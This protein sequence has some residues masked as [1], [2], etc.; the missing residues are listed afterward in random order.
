MHVLRASLGRTGHVRPRLVASESKEQDHD[1]KAQ[2]VGHER[3][4]EQEL[5]ELPRGP[6]SLQVSSPMVQRQG[7]DRQREDIALDQRGGQ[8]GPR[9]YERQ[10]R[11]E[12]QI[13]DDDLRVGGPLLVT[14]GGAQYALQA[15]S[16]EQ[17]ARHG[18]NVYPRRHVGDAAEE[19]QRLRRG[20]GEAGGDG[21]CSQW[22]RSKSWRSRRGPR[23]WTDCWRALVVQQAP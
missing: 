15:Q 14:D 6:G 8:E 23:A 10:L 1:T 12:V 13:R 16:D 2:R 21:G 20:F 4:D 7:A 9:I 3:G 19:K 18:R 17:D 11:D 22:R 5:C